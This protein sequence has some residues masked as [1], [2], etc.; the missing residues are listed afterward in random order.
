MAVFRWRTSKENRAAGQQKLTNQLAIFVF[1]C[2][3]LVSRTAINNKRAGKCS[4]ITFASLLFNKFN[5][6]SDIH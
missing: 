5:S 4:R 6:I 3:M 2:A 1:I